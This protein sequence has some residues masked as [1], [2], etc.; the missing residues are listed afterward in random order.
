MSRAFDTIKSDKLMQIVKD[1]VKLEEDEIR[2]CLSLLAETNLKVLSDPF[3][4]I[5]GSPPGDGLS[6]ILFAIYLESALRKVRQK[7]GP[8]PH[9][10]TGL[11]LD[12]RGY[13]R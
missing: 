8:R 9:V 7:A 13:I 6:P 3:Q 4:T 12:S 10:D 1:E 5:L 2:L 11:P